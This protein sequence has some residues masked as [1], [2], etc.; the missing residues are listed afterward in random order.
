M[1]LASIDIGTN[2]I[3]MLIADIASDGTV[4]VVREEQVIARLGKGVD[5]N[6]RIT[7]ETFSR[8]LGFL[9]RFKATAEAQGAT[10]IVASGTSVLRDASNGSEFVR[11]VKVRIGLEIEV[12]SGQEEAELTYRCRF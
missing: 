3:L 2:T 5:A 1:R 4:T 11:D 12:L 6:R 7:A 9:Q 10:T 8:V